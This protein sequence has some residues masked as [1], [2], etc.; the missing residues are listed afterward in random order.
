VEYAFLNCKGEESSE[1]CRPILVAHDKGAKL[2]LSAIVPQKRT[3]KEAVCCFSHVPTSSR[4][5]LICCSCWRILVSV[6]SCVS[7]RSF[8][9][10]SYAGKFYVPTCIRY[11][12]NLDEADA[13]RDIVSRTHIHTSTSYYSTCSAAR[14]RIGQSVHASTQLEMLSS[15]DNL[16]RCHRK[17]H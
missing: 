14:A 10:H 13:S 3:R 1:R 4:L 15:R 8:C 5:L 11:C 2:C 6:S 12:P 7:G 9:Q 17:H 16:S